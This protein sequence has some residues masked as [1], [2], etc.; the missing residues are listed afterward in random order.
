MSTFDVTVTLER[1]VDKVVISGGRAFV[2]ARVLEPNRN[3]TLQVY[4]T[5]V[6]DILSAERLAAIQA[7][8]DDAQA[9]LDSQ[10]FTI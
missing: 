10:P 7:L 9:W 8:E 5:D 1:R 3:A 6:T 4:E 2:I